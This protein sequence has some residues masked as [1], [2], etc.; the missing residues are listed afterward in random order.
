MLL[1]MIWTRDLSKLNVLVHLIINTKAF[2]N[3]HWCFHNQ[4]CYI[5][6]RGVD[7]SILNYTHQCD[8]IRHAMVH[9]DHE[10]ISKKKK[11][12]THPIFLV[13]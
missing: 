4:A 9:I 1:K 6:L 3:T 11:N 5:I 2:C 10:S 12:S 7:V 13:I 8:I